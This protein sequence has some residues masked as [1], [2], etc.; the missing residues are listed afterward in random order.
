[1]TMDKMPKRLEGM[2][3]MTSILGMMIMK[4]VLLRFVRRALTSKP[5]QRISFI[6][7]NTTLNHQMIMTIKTNNNARKCK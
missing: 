3:E 5:I 1:M 2:R 6:N 7:I 4:F